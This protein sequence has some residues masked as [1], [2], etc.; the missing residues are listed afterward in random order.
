[1]TWN[2]WARIVTDSQGT[3]QEYA[4]RGHQAQR[5]LMWEKSKLESTM[6]AS[7]SLVQSHIFPFSLRQCLSAPAPEWEKKKQIEANGSRFMPAPVN[8]PG[9]SQFRRIQ[10]NHIILLTHQSCLKSIA[11]L[12]HQYIQYIQYSLLQDGFL[13]LWHWQDAVHCTDRPNSNCPH[14]SIVQP[15]SLPYLD[16]IWS[17]YIGD[18]NTVAVTTCCIARINHAKFPATQANTT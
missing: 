9:R 18:Q 8:P 13:S 16:P 3:C 1:M 4:T 5:C 17:N 14:R 7:T 10:D 15:F 12:L 2:L 11:P 6:C